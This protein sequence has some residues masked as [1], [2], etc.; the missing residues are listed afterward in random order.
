MN[1]SSSKDWDFYQ[2][3]FSL[4]MDPEKARKRFEEIQMELIKADSIIVEWIRQGGFIPTD[5]LWGAIAIT[6]TVL[7]EVPE[8]FK[9]VFP[10]PPPD[11]LLFLAQVYDKLGKAEVSSHLKD[12]AD[13]KIPGR[14]PLERAF[15]YLQMS[16]PT[17]NKIS[18]SVYSDCASIA[19]SHG[20][21][22]EN[23]ILG[24]IFIKGISSQERIYESYKRTEMHKQHLEKMTEMLTKRLE[25]RWKLW[26]KSLKIRLKKNRELDRRIRDTVQAAESTEQKIEIILTEVSQMLDTWGDYAHIKPPKINASDRLIEKGDFFSDKENRDAFFHMIQSHFAIH[27]DPE[28]WSGETFRDLAVFIH[29]HFYRY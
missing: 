1:R 20:W 4:W 13:P 25:E 26:L 8:D 11:S 18:R 12:F 5:K 29:D 22:R 3:D 14:P 21:Q 24:S 16:V 10:F 15:M 27:L 19:I 23:R 28:E 6:H 7:I 2:Q 9:P 17:F